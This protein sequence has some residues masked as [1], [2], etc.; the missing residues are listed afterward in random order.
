MEQLIKRINALYHKSKAEGLTEEETKEQERLRRQYIDGVK[1][2]LQA[3]LDN[4]VIMDEKGNK[5]P[6]KKPSH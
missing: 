4:T 6:L 2:N 5:T 1:A 3:T